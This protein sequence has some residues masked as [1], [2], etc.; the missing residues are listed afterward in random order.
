MDDEREQPAAEA[1]TYGS[2]GEMLRLEREKQSLTLTDIAD[3]TRIP[4]RHLKALEASDHDALPASTYEIGFAKAYGRA[5]GLDEEHI[6][7]ELRDEIGHRPSYDRTRDRDNFQPADPARTPPRLMVWTVALIGILLVAGYGIWRGFFW[8]SDPADPYLDTANQQQV[9]SATPV[10]KAPIAPAG[11]SASDPVVL[12][13]TKEVWVRI[14]NGADDTLLMKTMAPGEK[15]EVP[16]QAENPMINIGR[17][18]A[19]TVTVGGREVAPL[20]PPERAIKD[21]GI[22]ARALLAR[23]TGGAAANAASAPGTT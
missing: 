10:A 18:E 11:P 8:T 23:D 1:D 13:A 15:F 12:T 4:M 20:G 21:I 9:A 6:A 16:A 2:V 14:Y 7:N 19:L 17:P 5:L 22:S 3:K